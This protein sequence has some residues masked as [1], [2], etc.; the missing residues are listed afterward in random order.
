MLEF[1]MELDFFSFFLFSYR[2][3]IL[4]FGTTFQLPNYVLKNTNNFEI[5]IFSFNS[6][7]ICTYIL[8]NDFSYDLKININFL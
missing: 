1:K 5:V 7:N 3:K 2:S 8:A 4:N 6:I